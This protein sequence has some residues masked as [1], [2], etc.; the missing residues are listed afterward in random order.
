[1]AAYLETCPQHVKALVRDAVM[2]HTIEYGPFLAR[3]VLS[4]QDSFE[5]MQQWC[6]QEAKCPLHGKDL[7][8]ALDA[9]VAPE[10]T[11]RTL[12]P[13]MLAGGDEP[14]LGWPMVTQLLAE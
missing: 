2:D 9:A 5:R 10:P 3:N 1:C 12:V 11:M 8:A 14:Q 13:Q 4:V 7:G 6:A